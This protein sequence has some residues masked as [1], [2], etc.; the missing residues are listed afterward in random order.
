LDMSV[1][2]LIR[3]SGITICPR[4]W[5]GCHCPRHRVAVNERRGSIPTLTSTYTLNP[6]GVSTYVAGGSPRS[7]KPK[8]RNDLRLFWFFCV[9]SIDT[10]AI[11]EYNVVMSETRVQGCITEKDIN[12]I[13]DVFGP[14]VAQAVADGK[15]KTFLDILII[16]GRFSKDT[17]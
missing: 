7:G 10:R 5:R 8:Q 14:V 4:R 13:A 3:F 12:E 2:K 9:F 17:T 6:C 1:R 16:L 15:A 11:R